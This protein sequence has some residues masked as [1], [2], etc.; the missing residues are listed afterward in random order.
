MAPRNEELLR[1]QSE[2]PKW[3]PVLSHFLGLVAILAGNTEFSV[4]HLYAILI[5]CSSNKVLS[6]SK[7]DGFSGSSHFSGKC[8]CLSCS[9]A[10]IP[11]FPP[12]FLVTAPLK[13]VRAP[14][15]VPFFSGSLNN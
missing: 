1:S 11:F 4:V 7:K 13:M 15:R 14:N 10:P 8:N 12:F 6:C 3:V 5:F 2:E 9:V